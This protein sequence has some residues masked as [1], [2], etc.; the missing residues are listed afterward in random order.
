VLRPAGAGRRALGVVLFLHGW[1]AIAPAV[2]GA[3]LAHLVARG[4]EV[5]YPVYQDP[6]FLSPET[7]LGNV[8]RG[9]RRALADPAAPVRRDG[10]VVAGHSAGG[11][12]AADYTASAGRLGLPVPRAILSA[13]PGRRLRGLPPHIPEIDP[14]RIPR[15]TRL[16]ALAGADDRTVGQAPA[17]RIVAT[18]S[19]IPA[20]RRRFVLVED[21]ALDDHLGPQRS[22]PAARRTF[23][24]PLDALIRQTRAA[25]QARAAR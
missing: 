21:P 7:A 17:R 19:R 22:T 5:I 12:L 13:Y 16:V 9:V 8:V 6:P 3:W 1:T 20:A 18:A 11:A 10:W 14:R 25:A 24:A 15:A 4:S 2:Y 23:W